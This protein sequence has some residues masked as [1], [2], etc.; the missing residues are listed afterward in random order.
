MKVSRSA[1]YARRTAA[2]GPRATR[3]AELTAEIT[4]VHARTRGL[5]AAPRVHAVLLH[6]GNACGRRRVARRIRAAGLAGRHRGADNAPPS[7]TPM[8]KSALTWS[9]ETSDPT[10]QPSTPAGAVTSP[11][12]RP[13]RA[14]STW[15]P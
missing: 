4:E 14:G 10:R 6:D 3:D 7:L 5:Y 13:V 8:R 2:P 1:Y 15:P 11:T 9:D 12:S